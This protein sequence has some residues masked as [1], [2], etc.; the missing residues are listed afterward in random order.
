MAL[1]KEDANV[2]RELG[3]RYM[4]FASLPVQQEKVDL[5][6][7]LNRGKMERP[8][9][10][11]NQYPWDELNLRGE[12]TCRIKDPFWAGV[13]SNLRRAIYQW[14]HCPVDMVLEPYVTIPLSLSNTMFSMPDR[15]DRSYHAG[16]DSVAGQHYNRIIKTMEDVAMIKD[17][18]ITHDEA[19]SR[20]HWEEAQVIFDGVVPLVQSHGLGFHLGVW[21]KLSVYIGMEDVYYELMDNP[22][23]IH[24]C[25][26]RI[27]EATLAGIRQANELKVHDDI[28]NQ[29]HCSY[30]YEDDR[31][32]GFN[33]GRGAV[34]Q[35]CW[36]FGMAQLFTSVSPDTTEEFETP[37][38]T[39]MAKEFGGIYYGCCE[40]EDDRLDL[41]KKIPHIR[42]VSCS[43][44]SDRR[45]F[46]EKIGPDLVMSNKPSPAFVATDRV[47]WDG[48][49]KDLRETMAAAKDNRVNLEFILKD[50]STVRND[51]SRL[52]KWHETAMKVVNDW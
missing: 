5:W 13:E 6:K 34:S 48:V 16:E 46:A 2:L 47:D 7:A 12:L 28:A 3:A 11:I 10:V 18:V 42:K 49:E 23:L 51:P 33:Q 36:A 24:A 4:E 45:L 26:D 15:T 9:V 8:M 25:M 43:P 20:V 29:C 19:L 37:Y 17:M 27:T 41:V 22:D 35:N 1:G 39:R 44:W 38:I 14:V 40:R 30:I 32:P 21:D 31:L 50:I 52:T